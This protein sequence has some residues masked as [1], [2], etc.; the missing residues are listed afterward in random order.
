MA[1]P[2]ASKKLYG[3]SKS[4]RLCNFTLKRTLFNQ[5]ETFFHYPFK[6]FWKV[7]DPNLENLFFK[8]SVTTFSTATPEKT[9]YPQNPSYPHKKVPR[10]ALFSHPAQCLV[11]V[12]A[13]THKSAVMRIHL[14]R[15]IRESYRQNKAPFYSFLRNNNQLCLLAI[16]YTSG[17]ALEYRDIESKI[18]VSL[19][20]IQK[21]ITEQEL[22]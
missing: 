14:K 15:L 22:R 17:E 13:K 1:I 7:I 11:G 8:K 21:K 9:L 20:K 12:S 19:Q 5:G 3:F 10:N 16:I 4:E 2:K 6:I 18:I